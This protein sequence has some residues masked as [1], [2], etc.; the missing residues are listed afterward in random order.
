MAEPQRKGPFYLITG[1]LIGLLAG[2]FYGW[3]INPT[4]YIDIAPQS[5][6]RD[7][8]KQYLLLIAQSYQ[9]NEDIGRSYARTKQMIDPVNLDSL[10]EMLLEMETDPDYS[11]HFDVVRD[12]IN[13][14]DTYIRKIPS[15]GIDEQKMIAPTNSVYREPEIVV[16][17][18]V[19]TVQENREDNGI[20]EQID[21]FY[22]VTNP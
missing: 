4:R 7:F 3:F 14:L 9:A 21:G 19:Q 10:R 6:H 15:T 22:V 18:S 1:L 20:T 5:L 16:T 2:L 11:E 13:D 17:Q 12:L 8:Q